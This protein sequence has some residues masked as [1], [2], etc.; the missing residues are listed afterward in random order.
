MIRNAT[1][2]DLDA[3]VSIYNAIH[4]REESGHTTTGWVRAVYPTR[5]TA[6]QAIQSGDLFVLEHQNRIVASARI[7]QTQ[8]DEYKLARWSS[9]TEDSKVMVL[10][11]LTVHPECSGRGFGTRF[12]AFYED[13]ATQHGCTCLRLDTNARN[14]AARALYKKLGYEEMSIVPCVFNGIEGVQLVCM[15]K[16]L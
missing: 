15:E 8:G 1:L 11:T 10:H 12:V 6:R 2:T 5:A 4:D 7:N 9:D 13:Y 14:T 3:V 16:L